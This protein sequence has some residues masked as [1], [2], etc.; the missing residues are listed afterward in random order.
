MSYVA[1]A[2]LR[3]IG[4]G[5]PFGGDTV[6]W[7]AIVRMREEID[8]FPPGTELHTLDRPGSTLITLLEKSKAVVLIDAM[9]SNEYPGTVQRLQLSDLLMDAAQPSSHSL[10]VAEALTL[11]K[12]LG[13]LPEI[14]L[15]YGIEVS[16]EL[17]TEQ[18]YPN[19]LSLLDRDILI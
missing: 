3:V 14:L 10:G 12:V 17:P 11:A 6:G 13:T 18:W 4:I 7:Q 19:L 5:S 15:I 1:K 16:D 2:P 9:Q 8:R